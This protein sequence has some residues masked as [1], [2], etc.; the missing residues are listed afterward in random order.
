[1]T[2]HFFKLEPA[3]VEVNRYSKGV[4][5]ENRVPG[6]RV[7]RNAPGSVMLQIRTGKSSYANASISFDVAQKIAHAL[8]LESTS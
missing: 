7:Y 5:P 1:M 8:T 6:V 4:G 3:A 2:D